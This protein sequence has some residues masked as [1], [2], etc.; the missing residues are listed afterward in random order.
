MSLQRLD[1]RDLEEGG[2][3]PDFDFFVRPAAEYLES[4]LVAV[5]NNLITAALVGIVTTCFVLADK[6]VDLDDASLVA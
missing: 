6:I 4:R 1:Q 5:D 2:H 3:L